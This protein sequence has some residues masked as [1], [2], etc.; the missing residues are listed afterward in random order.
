[1]CNLHARKVSVYMRY[2]G[3]GE[4]KGI[5][6]MYYGARLMGINLQLV[7]YTFGWSAFPGTAL[8]CGTNTFP[9]QSVRISSTL[10]DVDVCLCMEQVHGFKSPSSPNLHGRIVK[11]VDHG[12][13]S[14]WPLVYKVY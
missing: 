14:T 9:H 1:M 5:D 11:L 7:G 3:T 6:K 2:E 4:V 8:S 12:R 13:L 10:G